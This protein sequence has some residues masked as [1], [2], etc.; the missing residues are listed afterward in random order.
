MAIHYMSNPSN[1]AQNKISNEPGPKGVAVIAI[2]RTDVDVSFVTVWEWSSKSWMTSQ[3]GTDGAPVAY[4]TIAKAKTA[5]SRMVFAAPAI[6]EAV[7]A[8]SAIEVGEE[9]EEEAVPEIVTGVLAIAARSQT[10][11][12]A[13]AIM[14]TAELL[15]IIGN[16]TTAPAA[17]RRVR[18]HI[19]G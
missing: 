2:R 16:A 15:A 11:G 3:V 19:N 1:I 6:V 12:P 8:A 10:W 13:A 17:A 9:A 18:E 4:K 7:E 5:I 14:P